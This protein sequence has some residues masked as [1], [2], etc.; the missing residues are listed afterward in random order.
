MLEFDDVPMCYE[1]QYCKAHYDTFD[2]CTELDH[3]TCEHPVYKR[4]ML[5]DEPDFA[6]SDCNKLNKEGK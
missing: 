6:Q 3:Y 1:C 2:Y 5:I 4:G